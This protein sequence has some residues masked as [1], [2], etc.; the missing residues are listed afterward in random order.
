MI[1]LSRVNSPLKLIQNVPTRPCCILS[2][3][4]PSSSLCLYLTPWQAETLTRTDGK[5]FPS[6][7]R[8]PNSFSVGFLCKSTTFE[9]RGEGVGGGGGEGDLC[10]LLRVAVGGKTTRTMQASSSLTG[11]KWPLHRGLHMW[12]GLCEHTHTHYRS[13]GDE[14]RSRGRKPSIPEFQNNKLQR[15]CQSLLSAQWLPDC[16]RSCVSVI[17]CIIPWKAK[18]NPCIG[19]IPKSLKKVLLM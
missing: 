16:L 18:V 5:K 1:L 3:N 4:S 17:D 14:C 19:L 15:R 8:R 11:I 13:R 12:A 2:V 10:A 9:G 6:L 7:Q